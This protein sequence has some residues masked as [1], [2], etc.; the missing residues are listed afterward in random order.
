MPAS[1]TG[2]RKYP[3]VDIGS[4]AV[5]PVTLAGALNRDRGHVTVLGAGGILAD[6]DRPCTFSIG[7]TV[8]LRF[9]PP[10]SDCPL[11][12]SGVVRSIVPMRGLG[13]EFNRITSSDRDSITQ[14]VDWWLATH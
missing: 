13:I 14:A 12:C 5:V 1:S 11:V 7:G 9:T 2:P 4:N 3:R 8:E 10:G 6:V